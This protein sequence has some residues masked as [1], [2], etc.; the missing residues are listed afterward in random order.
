[1]TPDRP[2]DLMIDLLAAAVRAEGKG[3]LN[4]GKL[5]RASAAAVS[6]G[7]AAATGF[8][9][10]SGGI[11]EDLHDLSRR[12]AATDPDGAVAARIAWGAEM[13]AAGRQ[14]YADRFPDPYVCRRCGTL[15]QDPPTDCCER[16]GAH[17]LTFERFRPVYWLRR[18]QPRE[19]LER[20]AGNPALFESAIG[21]LR[22]ERLNQAASP[23]AWS[24]V[25]VLRHVRAADAVLARR[26]RLI[27][28]EDDPVLEF[29]PVFDWTDQGVCQPEVAKDIFAA[30][31]ASRAGTVHLLESIDVAD[32]RRT[33]RHEELGRVTLCEQASYFAAHELVHLRQLEQLRRA[34]PACDSTTR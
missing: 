34:W 20:L 12:L 31:A 1:M 13:V 19:V 6:R 9:A 3:Q 26:V 25:D 18:Y 4:I 2:G 23:R 22:A 10:D 17:P 29:Q 21:S 32:W 16:C 5:L 24:A 8:P 15:V 11:V 7:G 14:S 33:G 27:L 30:Y 28:D